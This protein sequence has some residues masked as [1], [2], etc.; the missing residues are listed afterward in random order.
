MFS[1]IDKIMLVLFG[2][3]LLGIIG[4]GVYIWFLGK[5]NEKRD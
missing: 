1:L 4:I 2:L 3:G 5:S